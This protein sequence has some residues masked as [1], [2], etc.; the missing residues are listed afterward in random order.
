MICG[1]YFEEERQRY[2][3]ELVIFRIFVDEQRMMINELEDE[4]QYKFGV[5][6]SQYEKEFESLKEEFE[7]QIV[8][9]RE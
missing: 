6:L 4:G 2:E 3:E 8:K 1:V 5:F 9:K 7:E